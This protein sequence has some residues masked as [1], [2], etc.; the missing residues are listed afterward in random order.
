MSNIVRHERWSTRSAI[1]WRAFLS[2]VDL[3]P[4]WA[5]FHLRPCTTLS[6]LSPP[7]RPSNKIAPFP[8]TAE[9]SYRLVRARVLWA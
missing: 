4:I 2:K 3:F 9:R 1:F 8:D 5:I 7:Q 6:P